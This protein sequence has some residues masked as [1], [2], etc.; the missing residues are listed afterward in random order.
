MDI[1][2]PFN[3]SAAPTIFMRRAGYHPRHDFNQ[4]TISYVRRLSGDYYPRFHVYWQQR[5]GQ[6]LLSLHLDHKKPSYPGSHAHSADYDG[7]VIDREAERLTGLIKQEI[8]NQAQVK[9]TEPRRSLF[10]RL[11]G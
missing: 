4:A 1:D 9:V 10:N 6:R 2:L 5:D 11:F 8:H 7:P 3:F